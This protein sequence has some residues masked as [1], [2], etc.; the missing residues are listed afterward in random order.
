MLEEIKT[1]LFEESADFLAE[2]CLKTPEDYL[3]FVAEFKKLPDQ[4]TD[5]LVEEFIHYLECC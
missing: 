3:R 2:T 4:I 1:E 5:E